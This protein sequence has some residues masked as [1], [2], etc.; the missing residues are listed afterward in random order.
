MAD[1]VSNLKISV[2][3]FE[4]KSKLPRVPLFQGA[5][6]NV[7]SLEFSEDLKRIFGI[8]RRARQMLGGLEAIEA[9]LQREEKGLASL[10]ASQPGQ[11]QPRITRVLFLTTDGSERFFRS[12]E[13]ILKKYNNR[14]LGVRLN[15]KANE[16]GSQF[17]GQDAEV[18]AVLLKHKSAVEAFLRLY[19]ADDKKVAAK[20]PQEAQKGPQKK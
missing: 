14:V 4:L 18:K 5:H 15:A 11:R 16:I 7:V 3:E 10:R 19:V 8:A 12:S 2:S 9:L 1:D 6:E 17:F 13:A 20:K